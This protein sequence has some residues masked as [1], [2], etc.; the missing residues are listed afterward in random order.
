VPVCGGREASQHQRRQRARHHLFE[1]SHV[2]GA[3]HRTRS[4]G[5]GQSKRGFA[6][7]PDEG[8]LG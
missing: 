8:K 4:H 7:P 2:R 3:L 6:G 1:M 5:E